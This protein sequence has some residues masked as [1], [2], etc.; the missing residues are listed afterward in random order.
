M[1]ISREILSEIL[2]CMP[3]VPPE[4]GGIL[5]GKD[6]K[7][8]LWKYDKGCSGSG[9]VYSP[10]VN[11]LNRI[12]AKWIEQG[13]DFMGILHVHFGGSVTLSDGDKRYI[14]KIMR[15]MPENINNLYFPIVAQ[16]DKIVVSYMACRDMS[17]NIAI[18]ENEVEVSG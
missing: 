10:N 12:I 5:G 13:Y 8:C 6:G 9:C 4:T 16:P 2:N 11:I 3:S 15:A 14:E 18:L 1:K 17:G 7:I